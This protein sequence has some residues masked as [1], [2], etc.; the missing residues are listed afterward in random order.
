VSSRWQVAVAVVAAA[1]VVGCGGVPDGGG[2]HLGRALPVVGGAGDASDFDVKAL[3]ALWRPGMGPDEV[4]VGFLHAVVNGDGDYAIARSYLSTAAAR[5]WDP[6]RSIT[7]YD[8]MRT[9]ASGAGASRLVRLRAVRTGAVDARGDYD[10]TPGSVDETLSLAR[11][12]GQWRIDR[13]PPG[14]LLST[15]DVQRSIRLAR[16]Y[17]LNRSRS[18]LVP[19]QTFLQTTRTGFAT[20]L[21][22]TLLTGPGSW[23]APAV[24]RAAPAGTTLLGNVPV[25]AGVADV[26]LSPSVGQATTLQL[27][28]MSAAIVWT[29]RQVPDITAVR[30]FV[31]GSPLPVPGVG[32]MQRVTA[33]PKFDPAGPL[34]TARALFV[35]A[36]RIRAIGGAL[37]AALADLDRAIAVA[38]SGNGQTVAVVRQRGKSMVLSTGSGGGTLVDRL[39]ART[40][41]APTIDAEGDV[42][43]VV[44]GPGGRKVLALP[45]SGAARPVG[46]DP[47]LLAGPVSAL[48]LS[49]DGAR[50]AAVVRGRLLIGRLQPS[51]SG[52]LLTG[53][54]DVLPAAVDVRG[55]A[56]TDAGEVVTT[57]QTG[58]STR[59]LVVTDVDGYSARSLASEG[60]A[61]QPVDVGA[62]PGQ[63]LLLV[64][65]VGAVW[66]DVGTWRRVGPG[67]A[68]AYPD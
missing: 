30:L 66:T 43:T 12:G 61:G 7:T 9:D 11:A 28:Q 53:F 39:T 20:A 10:P 33:W 22:R 8:A 38:Q 31:D 1:C 36:G 25:A 51:S 47:R 56:W 26:N 58:R 42:L 23:L 35:R 21:V 65:A 48:R 16:V 17:Y 50:V 44:D 60:V 59:G 14:V 54:R 5:S 15:L 52:L 63:P 57:V 2:V 27:Q 37:P 13:L 46:A 32:L 6:T 49:R 64:T 67:R 62:A 40:M 4:V 3:P 19:E 34:P 24:G 18:A 41:T 68:A 55:V 45:R 29:L